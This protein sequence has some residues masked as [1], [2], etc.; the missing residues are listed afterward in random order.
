MACAIV[1]TL[2]FYRQSVGLNL[3]L[4]QGI[5]LALHYTF[6][7]PRLKNK[8]HLLFLAGTLLSA[9]MV[10]VYNSTISIVTNYASFIMLMGFHAIPN[11]KSVLTNLLVG[12]ERFIVAQ[13]SFFKTKN[14][15]HV[16]LSP[17][18][19]WMRKI[20]L[21]FAPLVLVIVFIIIYYSASPFFASWFDK[22]TGNITVFLGKFLSRISIAMVFVG[23][24]GWL[25]S[26]AIFMPT[27]HTGLTKYDGTIA[28]E[29]RRKRRKNRGPFK[30]D[31]LADEKRMGIIL[32]AMLN[33]VLASMNILDIKNV[34]FGFEWDGQFLKQFVH[35]GTYLLI[36]S[37]ALSVFITLHY[38]RGSLNFLSNNKTLKTLAY[39][40]LAQNAI[41][42]IS[43]AVRNYH[44]IHHYALAY[45][46]IGVIFFLLLMLVV[47]TLVFLKIHGVKT[48]HYLLHWAAVS[49]YTL[50]LFMTFFNWDV[51]ISK[52]NISHADRSFLHYDYLA[53]M[54]SKALPVLDLSR[55]KL[56]ELDDVQNPKFY[57]NNVR[58]ISSE[59]FYNVIQKRKERF[60][61]NYPKRE[62]P[63]WNWADYHAYKKL[64]SSNDKIE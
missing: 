43:V 30:W 46:R 24:V 48:K 4:F 40:W 36:L 39:A 6:S 23:I 31:G 26:N 58:Y 15:P 62:W 61:E 17:S 28:F 35:G 3:L 7:P 25:I 57:E 10:V 22:A 54:S 19:K 42:T 21:V 56:N 51:M 47:L 34:W 33:V 11:P 60:I 5:A 50:M 49:G 13:G 64:I 12:I 44:Y 14:Q 1:F 2:L 59:Q 27:S 32:F 52:Y 55:D 45:G 53:S 16:K 29:L 38:F 41:L 63:S 37:I 9:V 18:F 8:L 20:H